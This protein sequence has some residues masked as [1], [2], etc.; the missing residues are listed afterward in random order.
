MFLLLSL[1]TENGVQAKKILLVCHQITSHFLEMVS[2]SSGLKNGHEV[3]VT[4]ARDYDKADKVLKPGI[5]PLYFDSIPGTQPFEDFS[6][7]VTKLLKRNTKVVIIHME[8][9]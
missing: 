8:N 4:L 2:M 5:K 7:Q 3:Y 6:G 9:R 1:G